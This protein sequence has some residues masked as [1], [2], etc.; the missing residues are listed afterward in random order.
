MV[1]VPLFAF[2]LGQFAGM[3]VERAIRE[4]EMQ[5]MSRP[6]GESEF[7][8][9]LTLKRNLKTAT[10]TVT[11]VP[12]NE[13]GVDGRRNTVSRTTMS[14]KVRSTFKD[15]SPLLLRKD[16]Q[17]HQS[18]GEFSNSSSLGQGI[19]PH[20]HRNR[21]RAYSDSC[22]KAAKADQQSSASEQQPP[23]SSFSEFAIDFGEFVVLEMLR[24]RRVDEHDLEAIRNL[25][26]DIDYDNAGTIDQAKLERFSHLL[27]TSARA[28]AQEITRDEVP[29]GTRVN[30]TSSFV[31]CESDMSM[32]G[33]DC[34][35]APPIAA[36]SAI[37]LPQY[38]TEIPEIVEYPGSK[39]SMLPVMSSNTVVQDRL[40]MRSNTSNSTQY[41]LPVEQYSDV[42]DSL[43]SL[44]PP[45][46]LRSL[47]SPSASLQG[48]FQ[49]E[50]FKN[51]DGD[52]VEENS[53]SLSAMGR[54]GGD[55]D[56]VF[57]IGRP[58]GGSITSKESATVHKHSIADEYNRLL[59]PILHLRHQASV[60][61]ARLGR[62]ER[63]PSIGST[64]TEAS[65]GSVR[66]QSI[67]VDAY[68]DSESEDSPTRRGART[69]FWPIMGEK[70]MGMG[71][72]GLDSNGKRVRDRRRNGFPGHFLE[73]G[74]D[75]EEAMESG[76]GL[77]SGSGSGRGPREEVDTEE[78][79]TISILLKS[80]GFSKYGAMNAIEE[81]NAT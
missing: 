39:G 71:M 13:K 18:G 19:G 17:H 8:F 69:G 3:I 27:H 80:F 59:M 76:L 33:H 78:E 36:H 54:S 74:S 38:Y 47:G 11:A 67:D 61:S 4:R 72:E 12:S 63:R 37:G 45:E 68:S 28:D 2:T 20:P 7:K 66:R 31:K 40:S 6:L 25:F 51:I 41:S 52:K 53:Q 56:G 42:V 44:A 5:I 55:S 73:E 79:G 14:E 49:K 43:T 77:G 26:D 81:E 32:S 30:G 35:T 65:P 75:Q 62:G 15:H 34:V 21:Q 50:F 23:E 29:H 16:P 60:S 1:G 57:D 64:A 24:L 48:S 58:R 22:I 10:A 46:N 9:A 70:G